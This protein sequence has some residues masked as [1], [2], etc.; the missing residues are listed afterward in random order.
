M[1]ASWTHSKARSIA[2]RPIIQTLHRD[3]KNAS[4]LSLDDKLRDLLTDVE[5]KRLLYEALGPYNDFALQFFCDLLPPER[6]ITTRELTLDDGS[7]LR[8]SG[9]NSAFV[10]SAADKAGDLFV[11]PACFQLKRI[12]RYKLL[13]VVTEIMAYGVYKPDA[14][15][16]DQRNCLEH[17]LLLLCDAWAFT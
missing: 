5:T 15:L 11:D 4:G 14:T 17:G 8:L 3:I 12:V 13:D 6:T 2:S 9:F 10:S 1:R 16:A 7:K